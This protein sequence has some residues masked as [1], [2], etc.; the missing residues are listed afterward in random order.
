[1]RSS[2]VRRV[3]FMGLPLLSMLAAGCGAIRFE[4][5][6]EPEPPARREEPPASVAGSWA[7][8]W[9]IEGQRIEGTL[10]VRQ[11]GNDLR[12]TFVSPALGG[13]A[14]GTGSVE[15]DGRVRLELKYNVSC[16]GTAQL[17]GELLEQGTRLGGTL[18]AS[19]CT[20]R[21]SG[22]FAFSRR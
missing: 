19:D 9:E 11:D 12:A 10:V 16:A 1:M 22:T 7:G 6:G 13:D 5:D 20:G 3:G 18:A 14:V 8:I 4:P 21:A 17:T 15:D 2:F